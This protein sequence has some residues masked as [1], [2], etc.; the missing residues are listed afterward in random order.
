[1]DD[2]STG[3]RA[4]LRTITALGA[5]GLPAV[6]P[7][8][9]L[10]PLEA[11]GQSKAKTSYDPAARFDI[12]VSEVE[13]RRTAAGRTLMARIYRPTGGGPFPTLLDLHRG[14]WGAQDR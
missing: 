6:L 4:F 1:M 8:L 10:Y 2:S 13:L 5:A 3:R 9:R 11:A 12:E 7:R 14:A